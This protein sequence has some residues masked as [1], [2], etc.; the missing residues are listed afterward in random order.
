MTSHALG[1]LIGGLFP[2]L[3]FSITNI[4]IK[5][6]SENG[7]SPPQYLIAMGIAV[8]IVGIGSYAFF[9][10]GPIS[11]KPMTFAFAAGLCW[12]MGGLAI[13]F[14]LQRF[15][16]PIGVLAPLFNMNTLLTVLFALWIFA[17][18][19]QVKVP[20]LLVGSLFIVIGGVLVTRA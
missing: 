13:M 11:I 9:K 4:L 12:G 3:V 10:G 16:T 17:E 8:I 19:K 5:Y 1:I 18:W 6:A 7:I 2:A 15:Q 20:H 14:T